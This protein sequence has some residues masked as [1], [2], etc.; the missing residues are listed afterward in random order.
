MYLHAIWWRC[1]DTGMHRGMTGLMQCVNSHAILL[2]CSPAALY[3]TGMQTGIPKLP[4]AV[5]AQG[6]QSAWATMWWL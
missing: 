6:K 3:V 5:L 2:H 1:W 4:M